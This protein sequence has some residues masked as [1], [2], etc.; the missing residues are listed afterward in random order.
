ML[1]VLDSTVLIDYLRGRPAVERVA[2]MRSRG[3]TAATTGINV[4]EVV[5]G[6][7]DHEMEAAQRLFSGLVV[8]PI[9]ARAG[10]RAGTW[11]R[12]FAARGVTLWQADCLLAA[13]AMVHGATLVT[14]NPK[15]FPMEGLDVDHWPVGG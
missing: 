3:D 5:R 11:R 13:T 15:D 1:R 6:L 10:W 12:E 8:L 14:G 4:E 2:S 9:D 7:R